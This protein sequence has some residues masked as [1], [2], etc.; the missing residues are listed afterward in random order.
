MILSRKPRDEKEDKLS[1]EIL[2]QYD[3]SD[4]F[5]LNSVKYLLIVDERIV[6]V[7]KVEYNNNIGVLKYI[8]ISKDETGDNLGDAL[9]RSIFNY[10]I[11]NNIDKIYYKCMDKYLLKIGFT[12]NKNCLEFEDEKQEFLL[13]LDL[14]KFFASPCK[15]SKGLI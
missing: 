2:K 6:G 3:I 15:S 7:S 11:N 9:L 8:V 4:E 14:E 5:K 10:C 13:E 1:N 12:E